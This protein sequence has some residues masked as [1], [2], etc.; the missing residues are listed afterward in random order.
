MKQVVQV[1][2]LG[3]LYSIKSEAPVEEVRRVAEFV[4]EKISEVMATDKVV[5]TLNTA[6]L[7]LLNVSGAYIRLREEGVEREKLEGRLR[8]LL[9]RLEKS[10]PDLKGS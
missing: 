8:Q 9:E 5:D 4:N 1:T 6:V 10:C 3:Q 7:A 2:I